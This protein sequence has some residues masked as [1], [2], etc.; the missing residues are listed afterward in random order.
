M[1]RT[2]LAL[3][4]VVLLSSLALGGQL[5]TTTCTFGPI[6][7]ADNNVCYFDT[8]GQYK[9]IGN[10]A[11]F[12]FVPAAAGRTGATLTISVSPDNTTFYTTYVENGDTAIDTFP[13]DN[14]VNK[15]FGITLH[16]ARYW[17]VTASDNSFASAVLRLQGRD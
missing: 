8:Y 14:T 12:L 1:K 13:G 10:G 3:I 9:T 6:S 11:A 15:A 17:K 2:I 4:G 5:W 7:G 16:P